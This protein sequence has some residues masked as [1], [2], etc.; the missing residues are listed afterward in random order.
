MTLLVIQELQRRVSTRRFVNVN[1]YYT[2]YCYNAITIFST[3][4]QI[5]GSSILSWWYRYGQILLNSWCCIKCCLNAFNP[6]PHKCDKPHISAIH[7]MTRD[8]NVFLTDVG[9][10]H[11]HG[12]IMPFISTC[13]YCSISLAGVVSCII[14]PVS[15]SGGFTAPLPDPCMWQGPCC[16]RQVQP[17]SITTRATNSGVAIDWNNNNRKKCNHNLSVLQASHIHS[18]I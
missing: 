8:L 18:C 16:L 12:S 2:H 15:V 9:K 14:A 5:N 17:V 7:V 1:A 4:R 13:F 3:S 11:V 10:Y 6:K